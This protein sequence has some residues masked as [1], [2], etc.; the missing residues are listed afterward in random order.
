VSVAL[1]GTGIQTE[2]TRFPTTLSFG[3]KDID[4]GATAEE[5]A[6]TITNTGS[7][8]VTLSSVAVTGDFSQLTDS[9]NDCVPAK[10]LAADE[11]CNVRVTFD[12][13]STGAKTGTATVS[14]D[15]GVTASVALDG[16]GIQTA[17]A[18]NVPSISAGSQDVDDGP[19]SIQ[20]ATLTNT[21]TE[22]V[23]LSGVSLGGANASDFA[24]LTGDSADCSNGGSLSAGQTCKVRVRFDPASTGAKSA[25]VTIISNAPGVTIAL[26][27][28]G[29]QT[30]LSRDPSALDFGSHQV[31]SGSTPIQQATVTNTGTQPVTLNSIRLLDPGAARFLLVTATAADCAAGGTLAAGGSCKLRALYVPQSVGPKTGTV[32][33]TSS[34]GEATVV[35]TARGTPRPR[36]TI[37]SFSARA[38]STSKKRLK[39]PVTP[40]NGTIRSIV[41]DIRT[42][43]GKLLGTGK[44]ASAGRKRTVVIRLKKRLAPGSYVAKARGRDAFGQRVNAPSRLFRLR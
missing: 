30:S 18:S 34:L 6:S 40:V 24:R 10:Q 43:G 33:F 11:T 32:V 29:I 28:R 22:N 4:E 39:V 5:H 35:L 19:T 41:V 20:Q 2:L 26:S 12:P 14:A 42:R 1:D 3:P 9:S 21:G 23:T 27:G 16:T 37:P 8:T 36:L 31:G 25:Q 15:G 17:L 13:S 7:E 44:L 38:S